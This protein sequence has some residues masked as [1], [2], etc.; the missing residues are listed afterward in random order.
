MFSHAPP[1]FGGGKAQI[2]HMAKTKGELAD[3]KDLARTLFISTALS[4]KDICTKVGITEKTMSKWVNDGKWESQKKALTTTRAEQLAL[5]YDILGK[6]NAAAKLA[7]EDDDP[8]TNPDSDGIIKIAAAI[9]K[10]E[11][12]AG[13]GEMI[14]T[15]LALLKFVQREDLDAAK[16]INKW[17]YIFIQDKLATAN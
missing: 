7:L 2:I 11:K 9:H 13:V 15:G 3:Q 4:Q 1:A 5:M 17:F 8:A 16:V 14:Q 12:E 6:M 10:L